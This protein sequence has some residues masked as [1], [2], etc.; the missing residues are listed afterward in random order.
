MKNELEA[1][2]QDKLPQYLDLLQSWVEVNSFTANGEGVNK[3]ADLTAEA[4]M[5]LGFK[6]ERVPSENP[7]FGKHLVL[8]RA[9]S[10]DQKIG[11]ITHL[12]T[13]FP[14]EE[15][16]TNDFHWR[17][18]D[19]RLYGPG[20]ND[21]KG[22]TLTIYMLMDV[23]QKFAPEDYESVT[24]VILAN[25]SEETLSPDFGAL[26]RN[27]L[28]GAKAALVFEAGF[29]DNGIFQLVTQ[30]KGMATYQIN[31]EGK[32]SHAGS[33]HALGANAIVQMARVVEQIASL[34]DYDKDLT[35]NVGVMQGGVVTNRV[36]HLAEARGEMRT[37]ELDVYNQAI[38][39]LMAL[40]ENSTI[41]SA[42]GFSCSV[43]IE[44]TNKMNPWPSNPNTEHIFTVWEQAAKKVGYQV[45]R[46]AR[47]G[48]SDGNHIWNV[49][50]S[51]D[52]LGPMGRNGHCSERSDDGSKD[53]EF[54]N[55]SSFVPKTVLNFFAIRDLIAER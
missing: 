28:E 8:T 27:R 52:G 17:V 50:P 31:V 25:S 1:Y 23:L 39:D 44:I 11:L 22:G 4:F 24:W 51:I 35:F 41:S 13:V 12:D 46:E 32:S 18:E 36:P 49:I 40:Q 30:R 43:E 15:E 9:G 14:P 21:I 42:D 54:A 6:D 10:S 55:K 19:D 34:T 5:E 16:I 53:Q 7:D 2:L 37:F 45:N 33:S 38:H 29:H 26:C 20:T 3:V 48:L 47:G